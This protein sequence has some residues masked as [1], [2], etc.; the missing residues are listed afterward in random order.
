M[1]PLMLL[2]WGGFN[3]R[4]PVFQSEFK[5]SVLAFLCLYLMGYFILIGVSLYL[6]VNQN[7]ESAYQF[8]QHLY[9]NQSARMSWP[10]PHSTLKII[11][12]VNLFWMLIQAINNVMMTKLMMLITAIPLFF[13]TTMTGLIDGLNQRAIRAACLGR[14]STYVFHKSLPLARKSICLVLGLWLCV[15]VTLSPTPIFVG[16]AVMLGLVARVSASRF[17]KYV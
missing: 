6:W 1:G 2:I 8:I 15:P 7:F 9:V 10:T 11:N 16:L 5:R 14:E 3:M 17:K 4:K 12:D 13:L